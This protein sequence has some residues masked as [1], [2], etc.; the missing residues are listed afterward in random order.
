MSRGWPST[1]ASCAGSPGS[2]RRSAI[3]EDD[4]IAAPAVW[5][6]ARPTIILPRGIAVVLTAEQL[7]WVLL[8]ELAH[9]RR[10]DLIVLTLQ[11]FAAILHFFNPAI[12]IANR[13]IH[14]LREYAC[15]DLALVAEPAP[16]RSSPERRSCGSC[17]MPIAAVAAWK[18][19]SASS[20]WIRGPPASSASAG[21]WIPSGRSAPRRARGRSGPDPAR[22]R[23][24]ASSARRRRGGPG[25]SAGPRR[26]EAPARAGQEFELRVVGPGGKPIPEAIVEL[27]ADPLPTAEQIRKG[28]FV[29]QGPYGSF[30]ATDAEGRLV[31]ELPQAPSRFNVFITIP[32]Y[33]PYWA[34]WSSETH[35]QPIPPRFTAELEA[36]WSV[37]GSS[38][39]P[40]GSRS[41]A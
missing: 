34:G 1:C 33:G 38:S 12:W 24:G 35:A 20:G 25:R 40:T 29:R 19:P 13:I 3:V 16:R 23:L 10:R 27:R 9:V 26:T 7:R 5:G 21:C 11:R 32:G 2:P 41:K 31:V 28:K 8:H 39:T 14:Q 18:G 22:R 37:G 17:S 30:V 6:I 4:A 36:A 15:D